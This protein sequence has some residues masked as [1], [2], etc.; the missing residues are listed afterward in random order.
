MDNTP[1][2]HQMP[3]KVL[4]PSGDIE[5]EVLPGSAA[6]DCVPCTLPWTE[7]ASRVTSGGA[8]CSDE[9]ICL[10]PGSLTGLQ[11]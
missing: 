10:A 2:A 11:K 5:I 9:A 6:P 4:V 8:Y 7:L 1:T 3:Y